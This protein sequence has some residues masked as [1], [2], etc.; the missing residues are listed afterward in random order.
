MKHRNMMLIALVVCVV[1][2]GMFI[3]IKNYREK[4][5][6]EY[7]EK[8]NEEVVS[9]MDG[10][11][12]EIKELF[13]RNKKAFVEE[14]SKDTPSDTIV[15]DDEKISIRMDD[16]E[17]KAVIFTINSTVGKKDACFYEI[18]IV[19]FPDVPFEQVSDDSNYVKLDDN[20]YI[21]KG[22]IWGV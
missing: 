3:L 21:K 8:T 7:V 17:T 19:Y 4:K 9:I 13:S 18:S 16:A 2:A 15:I 1:A 10:Y 12:P 11:V 22:F 14:I 6:A 5:Y 20:W